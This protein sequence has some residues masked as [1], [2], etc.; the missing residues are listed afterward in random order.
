MTRDEV[1]AEDFVVYLPY[2]H[3]PVRGNETFENW[4]TQFRA[5][6]SDFHCD[7]DDL[8]D[9]GMKVAVRLTWTGTHTG[10]LLISEYR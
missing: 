6:F 7:I 3:H 9:D 2:D 8:I 4:M 5:A 10:R 1:L